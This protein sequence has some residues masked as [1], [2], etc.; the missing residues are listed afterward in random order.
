[1]VIAVVKTMT[2]CIYPV[3]KRAGR[4]AGREAGADNANCVVP[5]MLNVVSIIFNPAGTVIIWETGVP[6][7]PF[8]K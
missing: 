8:T 1:V 4:G 2:S 7:V 6:R 3:K 5:P